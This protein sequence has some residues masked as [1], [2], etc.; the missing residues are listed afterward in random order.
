MK[1]K[2]L[3][4]FF[5][6]LIMCGCQMKEVTNEYNVVPLPVSMNEQQGRFY[7]DSDVP[8][9][10]N[11]SEEVKEIASGLS[12]AVLDVSGI[13]L[14]LADELHENA[15]AILFDS[16]PGMEKEAYKLSVTPQLIKITASTP[17][18]FYY[19]LQ[20]L[21]QLMPPEIFGKEKARNAEWSVPCVEI[22][23]AP[24]FKYRG[25]ML[26]PC[27]HFASVDY[28]KKF[29]DVLAAHKM[30]TFHWHLT[31][32]QGWRIEIKKYP[33]LTEIGSQRSETMVDY[34]Y[35]HYPFKYDGK[36][37]G[38][39][40]TQ[41]EIKDV[42][43]YAKSKYITVIPEIELPGHALAAIASYPE[44]S[45]TPD[46]TYEVCKLWGVFDQVFC[47]TDTFFHFM[48]GVMDEV[49]ELFPSSYIH[50]GGDECPKTAWEQ[51]AHCQKLIR[52]LGLKDDVT[53]NAI[54]GRKH[55]KEEKLQ[56]YIVG[57]VEKYLNSK[58]R[59]IIGWDEILEG[60]LA[61]NATVMSWR[62]VEGGITAANAGHD[63]IMTPNPYAYLD[64]YQE[65]PEI[66]PVTI[67]GYNTLKK[68]YSYNP[69]PADADSLVKEHIIGLQANCWA[70][71]MPTEDHRDYQIFPRLIAIAET[72]W[73][74]MG[75]KNFASFCNRMVEDFRRLEVMGVKPCRNFFDVNINTRATKNGVLNV[76]LE[77]FYPG[78]QIY[79]TTDGSEPSVNANLYHSPFVLEGTYDLKAAAFVDGK[80]IGK[81]TH[82]E[83]Y[84]NLITGKKYEIIPEPKGMKGDIL[85]ENDV[86]GAD[87][88]TL[89]LTNGKRGNNASST[90][91][92]GIRPDKN[93]MV[94][95]T[96]EFDQAKIGKV[97]FGTLYN[98]AGG[99]LPVSKA[100][101]YVAG[102]DGKLVKA[103]EKEFTYD[104]K[105]NTFR[106]FDEEI[107]FPAQEAVKVKIE[108]ISGG[109]IR[110]GID[111]YSPNDKSE[112]PSM[113][114]LDEIEI[115]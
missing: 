32:D 4:V 60:G 50:I 92:V 105:E 56:S 71:Y 101:V 13:K 7:L 8:I 27:R 6:G 41:E 88:V 39:F 17:N 23:D 112:V 99:I 62:G 80:Q 45:C 29:I 90:P 30:N 12:T 55:N 59:N 111:C 103:A 42:V 36:P 83:L 2:S 28:I 108:F 98:A 85:G 66:A 43:A 84:K 37:H 51:C 31:D 72:G 61:P 77:T 25:A 95:F 35:T 102:A 40:Y 91:W 67:G 53:P 33:K 75:E 57:R 107:E 24:Q 115:Y 78:A 65:E 26:D 11:A 21:Y 46:S 96:V 109:K 86:L 73:T 9:V 76:E 114:A 20:T 93:D 22:E 5:I 100:V 87:T 113:L 47:P 48:E 63:A 49:V 70:E 58:G 54:D 15:P 110:N 82:K 89:G 104:I 18:G 106:G 1:K 69:V 68:T 94:T 38:G 3:P 64:H 97:R 44:L 16:I 79:Y 34:F 10:V 19:G 52:D 74:P 14:K 81:V